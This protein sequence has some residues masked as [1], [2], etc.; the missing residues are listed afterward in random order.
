MRTWYKLCY[1]YNP[2]SCHSY[3]NL[4]N[5]SIRTSV[6]TILMITNIAQGTKKNIV[7]VG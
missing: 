4:M 7:P 5:T 3:K 6:D 2:S 1:F